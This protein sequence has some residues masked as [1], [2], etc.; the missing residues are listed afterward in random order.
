MGLQESRY[1]EAILMGRLCYRLWVGYVIEL[2]DQLHP[3]KQRS[4]LIAEHT[5]E[6]DNLSIQLGL[7]KINE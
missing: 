1:A 7:N 3:F 2:Y 5:C 4:M 6:F